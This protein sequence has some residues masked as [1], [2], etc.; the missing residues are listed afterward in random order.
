MKIKIGQK[1]S[2]IFKFIVKKDLT[3][4]VLTF[5]L[6]NILPVHAYA[7]PG[8]AIGAII[9]LF[10]V[11]LAFFGSMILRIINLLKKI[12]NFLFSKILQDRSK[13]SKDKKSKK[14]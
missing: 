3:L 1:S 9:V 7:G 10:T 11:L 5:L 12:T 13:N 2:L 8:V 14:L 6:V 4:F